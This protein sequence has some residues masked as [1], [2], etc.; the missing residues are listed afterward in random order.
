MS[1]LLDLA[2]NCKNFNLDKTLDLSGYPI[3]IC[4]PPN[5][6]WSDSMSPYKIRGMSRTLVREIWSI[7]KSTVKVTGVP[8]MFTVDHIEVIQ[9]NLQYLPY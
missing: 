5:M 6:Y 4:V 7:L 1:A 9:S 8:D 3:N 2:S